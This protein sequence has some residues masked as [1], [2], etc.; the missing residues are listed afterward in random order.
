M[1]EMSIS[2]ERPSRAATV[3]HRMA[4]P[5]G[6][7]FAWI[8]AALVLVLLGVAAWYFGPAGREFRLA[9]AD[10]LALDGETRA[11]PQD[12]LAW[13]YLGRR[14]AARG[15][16]V[17]AVS[18]LGQAQT[19]RPQDP[20]ILVELGRALLDTGQTDPA[21]Q[22]LK[23]AEA[24]DPHSVEAHR[25][26][27]RLYQQRGAYHKAEPY[28]RA[29]VDREPGDA[30]AWRA[31][32][33]CYLQMQKIDPAERS[34]AR[35][36]KLQP[37]DAAVLRVN[38]SVSAARGDV[39]SARRYFE[40]AV[41]FHP[42]DVRAQDDLANFLLSQSRSADGVQRAEEAVAALERLAPGYP[43]IPWHRGRVAAFHEDWKAAVA[44]LRMTV[45]TVPRLDDAYFALANAY[46]R[47]GA[48]K[49]GDAAMSTFLRRSEMARQMNEI[50][51]RLAVTES[52][53]LYFKLARLRREAGLLSQA[54]D[55]VRQGL[56]LSPRDPEGLAEEKRISQAEKQSQAGS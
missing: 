37:R 35:A 41:R 25:L 33:L 4:K 43:L 13:Y 34:A 53:G 50:Q 55:A 3:S 20:R 17:D 14:L 18:A 5:G 19:L 2:Q 22:V 48:K 15:A 10:L 36:L 1:R 28:W 12:G 6:P 52:P 30:Q 7:A 40:D 24:R 8:G 54:R 21:F 27:G 51:I 38:G 9:H 47:L 23:T 39:E 29:V 46:Y 44:D 42:Q 32:A 56:Q 26:L 16:T 49:E 11:A 45:Q 31:L